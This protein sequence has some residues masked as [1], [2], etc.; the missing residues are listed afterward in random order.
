MHGM[1]RH[2]IRLMGNSKTAIPPRSGVSNAIGEP[3]PMISYGLEASRPEGRVGPSFA[4][5][6]LPVL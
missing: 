4:N 1:E 5:T 3:M 2:K 6:V